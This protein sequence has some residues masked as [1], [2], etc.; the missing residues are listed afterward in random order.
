MS[1]DFDTEIIPP[2]III[3]KRNSSKKY[4]T[5]SSLPHQFPALSYPLVYS[6]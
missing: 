6:D 5:V 1:S 3:P 4:N 2:E